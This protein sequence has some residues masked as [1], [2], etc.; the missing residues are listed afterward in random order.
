M[1]TK[2]DMTRE[3][4]K[5]KCTCPCHNMDETIWNDNCCDNPEPSSQILGYPKTKEMKYKNL[6]VG[7]FSSRMTLMD[8]LNQG[9]HKIRKIEKI[10]NE[11]DS[12]KVIFEDPESLLE[13][14]L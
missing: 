10:P 1:K 8:F 11:Y 12:W 2:Q 3:R 5:E 7:R 4:K 13:N 6:K 14:N 9:Y